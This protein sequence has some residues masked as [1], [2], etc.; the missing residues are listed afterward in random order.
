MRR[1]HLKVPRRQAT[2]RNNGSLQMKQRQRRSWMRHKHRFKRR[3]R[4]YT[5]QALRSRD[6]GGSKVLEAKV[7]ELTQLLKD[8]DSTIDQ[9]QEL[10]AHDRDIR[11]LMGARDLYVAEVFDV[12]KNGATQ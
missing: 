10:L 7:A 9:Q 12:A 4:N 8:R 2:R 1:R 3:R 5:L 6:D 11:E